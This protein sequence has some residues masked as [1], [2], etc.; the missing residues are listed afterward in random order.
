MSALI[1]RSLQPLH[2][3]LCLPWLSAASVL[4]EC[5]LNGPSMKG[6][7]GKGLEAQQTQPLLVIDT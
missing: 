2:E 4:A 3:L 5:A 7:H 6:E 1:P